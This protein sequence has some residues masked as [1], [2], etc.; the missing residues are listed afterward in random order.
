[1]TEKQKGPLQ[2]PAKTRIQLKI[3]KKSPAVTS[4]MISADYENK[5][6]S[7]PVSFFKPRRFP[8]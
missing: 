3:T 2:G 5:Q 4:G 7:S 6:D 8:P 1:L